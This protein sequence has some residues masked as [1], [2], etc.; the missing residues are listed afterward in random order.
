MNTQDLEAAWDRAREVRAPD[1]PLDLKPGIYFDMDF[2]T[3][4]VRIPAINKSR[5][6][7]AKLSLA[8]YYHAPPGD[9]SPAFRMGSLVHSGKL[10]PEKLADRYVVIPESLVEETQRIAKSDEEVNKG[11]KPAERFQPYASPKA[12]AVY[13]RLLAAFMVKH[14]GKQEVSQEWFDNLAGM[15]RSMAECDR[16]ERLFA[17]GWPEV[18]ILWNDPETGLRCKGRIDWL[19]EDGDMADLKTAADVSD[20]SLDKWDY[21]LQAA[22][23]L[24]GF[25]H[26]W[27]QMTAG[28]RKKFPKSLDP[29]HRRGLVGSKKSPGFRP[30][31][32]HFVVVEKT[33]PWTVLSAP[34]DHQTIDVGAAEYHYLLRAVAGAE[35][36][37]KEDKVPTRDAWKPMTP[38]STW[39]FDR[40]FRPWDF[41]LA[42]QITPTDRD[43]FLL[44]P[45][46]KT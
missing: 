18:T 35:K 2:E 34:A 39:T 1:N 17:S 13:K 24:E 5:L 10:E 3:E 11:R 36:A 28:S 9:D 29:H 26:A 40:W 44:I 12:S 38:P 16:T 43:T 33:R 31:D 14:P 27:D 22:S 45:P 25:G 37:R 32:F 4:Y 21:H 30:R 42:R 8:H 20:W 41:P 6:S 23:Y 7:L 46:P 15:L 19:C